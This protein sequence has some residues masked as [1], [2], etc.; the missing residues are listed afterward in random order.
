M[1]LGRIG[2]AFRPLIRC[3][4]TV[5]RKVVKLEKGLVHI[6]N[7][8]TPEE[9]SQL[10]QIAFKK[11]E[12]WTTS[13]GK[14]VLNSEPHRGRTY[15]ATKSYPKIMTELCMR[16]LGIAAETDPTI[17]AVP[18]THLISLYYLPLAKPPREGYIPWHQDTGDNDG[19]KEFPVVS[20][21]IGDAADFLIT[22]EKPKFSLANRGVTLEEIYAHPKNLAHNI[23]LKS[24][25][26]LIWY[27]KPWHSF[28]KM[29]RTAPAFLPFTEGRLNFT[30]RHTPEL[31][32]REREFETVPASELKKL[33]NSQYY[34]LDKMK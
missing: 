8:L 34:K 20:F 14:K 16:S 22:H 9:Q 11:C 19:K 4:A 28:Y 17:I 12:F 3:Y 1:S 23:C 13:K 7:A 2:H 24:G 30:F 31:I 25:S 21:S 18:P 6:K 33:R 15:G 5:V 26:A 32:G 29:Y 10:A 27:G